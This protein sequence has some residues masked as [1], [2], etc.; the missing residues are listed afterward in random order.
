ATLAIDLSFIKYL[1]FNL[2]SSPMVLHKQALLLTFISVLGI[3]QLPLPAEAECPLDLTSSNFTLVASVCS[4][5]ADRAK[6]CR[7]MNAFVA[8]SVSR[9]AN[10]TADLGVAPDLTSICITTISRTMELYGIP[11]NATLFCG[12]GTKILVSYDCED[13]TTV[14]QMLRSPKFGD[15]SRN[16]ELPFRCKS[17]LN[18][19]ITYIRSLVDRGNN[20]KMSTC[21]DAT[22]AALASRVDTTSALELASCFFNVSELTTTP[23]FPPSPEASPS[24]E[25]ADS[26]SGNDDIVL[27]PRRSHHGYHLTVVPAIGIAVTVF[28][29]MMLAVLIVLIQRKK[30]ELDDDDSEGKDH[31]PTKTLPSSL[32]KVMMIH[33]VD[34]AIGMKSNTTPDAAFG[35]SHQPGTLSILRSMES[36]RYYL[37]NNL[38]QARRKGYDIVMTTSLSSDVPVGYFSW[39]EYDVMAPVQPKTEK[40]LAAAFISNCIAQN[41]RL[42]ALEALMEAN[43]TIDSYVEKVEALKH[44]KFSLAFENTNEEDYVTE[45]FFQSLVAVMQYS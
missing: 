42:Q 21:R 29:V 41:F 37:Q 27:S 26:P 24:P 17:C 11:T 31:N 14:T 6:C 18:S 33:E 2:C 1:S 20:I 12:L 39:A 36:A 32:P 7:Y 23:E 13:L 15:V 45:K 44:Y 28:S 16:C 8:V 3:H 30:R 22:Y 35:L 40:A 5:N 38:A 10:H 25:L 4:T 19:G 34:C 43:V 9:Y